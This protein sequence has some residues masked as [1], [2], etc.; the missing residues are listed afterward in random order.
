MRL[1]R[2]NSSSNICS[3]NIDERAIRARIRTS[4]PSTETEW[5]CMACRCRV[6]IV[7]QRIDFDCQLSV[8]S[9]IAPIASIE[10]YFYCL[11][12][13]IRWHI[14]HAAPKAI[15][16]VYCTQM[17][18][19]SDAPVESRVLNECDSSRLLAR[20]KLRDR[21]EFAFDAKN[22]FADL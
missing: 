2:I 17:K 3:I 18:S 5:M 1:A 22:R 7:T 6:L 8:C 9:P 13:E 19:K 4:E 20:R 14:A 11:I 21:D 16:A 15:V 12:N 10:W